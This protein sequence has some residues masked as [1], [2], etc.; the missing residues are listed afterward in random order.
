MYRWTVRSETFNSVAKSAAFQLGR[1]WRSI[2]SDSKR[3]ATFPT[4]FFR[5]DDCLS[6]FA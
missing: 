6:W 4:G 1:D 3:V 2:M 5:F